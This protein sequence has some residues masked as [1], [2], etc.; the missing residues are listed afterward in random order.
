MG[1]GFISGFQPGEQNSQFGR[2]GA[3]QASP[4]ANINGSKRR[5]GPLA[6]VRTRNKIPAVSEITEQQRRGRSLAMT[7][8]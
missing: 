3:S 8:G 2:F 5:M 1:F 4:Q 7:P 6:G